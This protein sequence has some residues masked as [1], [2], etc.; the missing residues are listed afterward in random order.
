MHIMNLRKVYRYCR[1]YC[2][3]IWEFYPIPDIHKPPIPTLPSPLSPQQPHL[4]PSHLPQ[5]LPFPVPYIID[6]DNNNVKWCCI[7]GEGD[8]FFFGQVVGQINQNGEV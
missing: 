1:G 7:G 3:Y 2:Q 6:C 8:R 5:H 4:P